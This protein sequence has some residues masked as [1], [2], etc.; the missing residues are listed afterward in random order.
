MKKAL[1][2]AGIAMF[3][4]ATVRAGELQGA[5]AFD[6]ASLGAIEL[7]AA[8]P[9]SG[10]PVE[11]GDAV[12]GGEMAWPGPMQ[13]LKHAPSAEQARETARRN[14]ALGQRFRSS[15]RVEVPYRPYADYEKIG[16]LLLSAN[17]DLDSHH[18]KRALAR[19]LPEDATLVLFWNRFSADDKEWLLSKYQGAIDPKRIKFL[20]LPT[21][22]KG[23]W[24]RDGAPVPMIDKDNKLAL[25]DAVYY[26]GFEADKQISE[27]FHAGYAKHDYGFEGGNFQA[28]TKGD[29]MI[30]NNDRHDKIPNGIF[31]QY[32]GCKQVIR[33]P[34]V[35][36]IGHVDE[37]AR[38]INDNVIVTSIPEYKPVLERKGFTVHM[39]PRPAQPYETYVNSL[40]MN[41]R[42][43]VPIFDEDTDAQ[44]L[45]VYE[46]LGLKATGG[47]SM[48]LSN[49]G[50]G[51]IHCI[52]MTYPHVPMADLAK[53][54]GGREI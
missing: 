33:L 49:E 10:G 54:L 27:T 9:A 8:V 20:E 13:S 43:V 40:I 32:Y 14:E 11:A 50:L 35:T 47:Y 26:H 2:L 42:V 19:A 39:L 48:T 28:N 25:I 1:V 41:D 24:A 4:S 52:T 30:V 12:K 3:F 53:A 34:H 36:G 37:V 6:A 23:F 7:S 51:S 31:A 15:D 46:S 29:C 5:P 17:F 44:A 18:A 16:Y 22:D 21:G 45:A 38:F